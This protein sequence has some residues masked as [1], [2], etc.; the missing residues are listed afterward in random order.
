[1]FSPQSKFLLWSNLHAPSGLT[2]S[3]WT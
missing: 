3:M 2:P 1:V